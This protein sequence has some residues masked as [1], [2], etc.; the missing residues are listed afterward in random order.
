MFASVIYEVCFT[1]SWITTI[2][3]LLFG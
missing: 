1:C 2:R 3:I